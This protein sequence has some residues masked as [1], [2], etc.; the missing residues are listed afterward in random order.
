VRNDVVERRAVT[1]SGS[2][3]DD[4]VLS[5]GVTDGE[6]VVLDGPKELSDGA[7]VKEK[8]P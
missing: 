7:K 5:A 1:V 6:R 4:A 3:G 2:D 8:A